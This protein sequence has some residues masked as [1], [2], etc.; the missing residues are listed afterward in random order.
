MDRKEIGTQLKR[1]RENLGYSV[2]YVAD[3]CGISQ[4]ALSMYESGERIPRDEVK[5]CLA[6]FYNVSV[7]SIF[8]PNE[9]HDS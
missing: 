7:S 9:T 2:S 1:L 5:I 8:F 6:R 4:S 3:Q